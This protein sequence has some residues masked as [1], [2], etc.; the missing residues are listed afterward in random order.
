MALLAGTAESLLSQLCRR[1]GSAEFLPTFL[2]AAAGTAVA[3]FCRAM[4]LPALDADT[5]I[6]GALMGADPRRRADH[7]VRDIIN[8]DYLSGAIRLLD[9]L[10]VAG[11]L[12]CGVG[13]A[14]TLGRLM[15][16]VTL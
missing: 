11:C 15:L 8:G 6:I 13:V 3:L 1:G 9:A 5:A 2:A 14:Y 16:G 7:G 4:F 10:L 12:A